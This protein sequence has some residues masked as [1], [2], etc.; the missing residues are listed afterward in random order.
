MRAPLL[1]SGR[2]PP[3]RCTQPLLL[4]I[5]ALVPHAPPALCFLGASEPSTVPTFACATPLRL[6]IHILH[7]HCRLCAFPSLLLPSWV[8]VVALK[9]RSHLRKILPVFCLLGVRAGKHVLCLMSAC[10][11]LSSLVHFFICWVCPLSFACVARCVLF[12]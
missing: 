5:N 4:A 2:F 7:T 1:C 3:S 8:C 11:S 6:Y 10:I 12:P 9:R